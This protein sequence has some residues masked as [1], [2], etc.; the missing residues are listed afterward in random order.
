MRWKRTK[1][2]DGDNKGNIWA[3]IIV[4]VD[5]NARTR[6]RA[7]TSVRVLRELWLG[8]WW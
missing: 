3:A 5:E 8:G 6:I 4:P 7:Y 1:D 2:V